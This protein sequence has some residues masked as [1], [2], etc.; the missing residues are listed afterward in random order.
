MIFGSLPLNTAK[1]FICIMFTCVMRK[2]IKEPRI[3][4]RPVTRE[5]V[6]KG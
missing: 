2:I 3:N 4:T 1:K 6:D 5:G